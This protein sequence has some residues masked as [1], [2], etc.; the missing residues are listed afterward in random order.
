LIAE[1]AGATELGYRDA[2]YWDQLDWA[3]LFYC[4][5]AFFAKFW[6]ISEKFRN[7]SDCFT[8]ISNRNSD[9]RLFPR[10]LWKKLSCLYEQGAHST[11]IITLLRKADTHWVGLFY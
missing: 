11:C 9:F 6:P 5:I 4:R 1:V 10:T 2:K 3:G 7:F 8:S